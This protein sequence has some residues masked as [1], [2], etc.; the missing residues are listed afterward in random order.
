VRDKGEAPGRTRSSLIA[1]EKGLELTWEEVQLLIEAGPDRGREF[2]LGDQPVR[3]GR[4]TDVD[5][6]LT[7]PAVSR[8]HALI[9][10]R[11]RERILSDLDS[12]RGTFLD[13]V[14]IESAPLTIG[15][16][17]T[18]GETTLRVAARSRVMRG[19]CPEITN[20]Y[21]MVA[22]SRPMR[23]LLGMVERLA[24]TDLSVLVQGETGTGKEGI[25]RALHLASGR[26]TEKYH[27]VDCTLLH[28]EHLRSELFGHVAGAF[29]GAAG[30]RKGAFQKADGGTLFFDEIGELAMELQ[31]GLLR[32]LETGEISPL[33][34]SEV[35]RARVRVVAATNR[36]LSQEVA[37]GRFR[38]D[39]LFRLSGV[40]LSVPPLR[41]R[42][43][44][45][46]PLTKYF[47]QSSTPLS[48][49]VRNTLESYPW[50]GNVRE[51]RACLER[52]SALSAGGSLNPRDLMLAPS[53]SEPDA[54]ASPLATEPGDL[55]D[56]QRWA[57]QEAL[58]V[59]GGSRKEAAKK[60][61]VPLST[62]Y[63]KL[64]KLELP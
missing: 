4:G 1:L 54:Q 6:R 24:P 31:A 15:S 47:L 40:V 55:S 42:P 50:P 49:E 43:E 30:S 62:F 9:T 21:G 48:E 12:K 38:A 14:Q 58:R 11:G 46:L 20:R 45:I 37:A 59:C 8:Q 41:E 52:A 44:D 7:D 29:T 25:A 34:S 26:P 10:V 51:L 61:G 64:K 3:L 53:S 39:L 27:V 56:H 63:R 18:L 5:L 28:S 23:E 35:I 60:L 13:G 17:L 36:D 57:Y 32:A 19:G 16:L 22:R 33:G 2:V